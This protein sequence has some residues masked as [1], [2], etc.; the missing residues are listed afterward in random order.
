MLP[1]D[2]S[3]G[4]EV[5]RPNDDTFLLQ[6][7]LEE[8]DLAGKRVLDMGTGSGL[9]AYTA[10]RQGGEVVATDI[11]PDALATARDN[12]AAHG[13]EVELV[14]SDMFAA[15]DGSYD[16]ILFNP[17]YVPVEPELGTMEERAWAG[18]EHGRDLIDRFV[19]TAPYHLADDGFILLLQCERNGI[20]VTARR[21]ADVGLDAEVVDEEKLSWERLVVIRATPG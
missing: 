6:S 17:P 7:V 9:L 10:A 12:F 2:W 16:L 20:D 14:E 18:G 19:A 13:V 1:E 21:C 8:H 15:I 3:V 4:D 11:N 5:Y